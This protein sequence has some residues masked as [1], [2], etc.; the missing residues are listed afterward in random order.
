MMWSG[1]TTKLTAAYELTS[2]RAEE[3]YQDSLET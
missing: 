3:A 1:L 2:V